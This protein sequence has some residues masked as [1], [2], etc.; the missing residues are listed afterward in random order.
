MIGEMNMS[1]LYL[2]VAGMLGLILLGP[3]GAVLGALIGIVFG[4]AQANGKRIVKLEKEIS[5]LKRNNN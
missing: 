2:I 4:V 5:E 3:A 1:L